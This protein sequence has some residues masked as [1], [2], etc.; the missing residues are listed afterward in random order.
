MKSSQRQEMAVLRAANPVPDSDFAGWSK[1]TAA[2]D[3]L[4][5]VLTQTEPH[6]GLGLQRKRLTTPLV[7][8]A[9]IATIAAALF[10]FLPGATPPMDVTT[11]AS[12]GRSILEAVAATASEQRI[13]SG[14]GEI[15]YSKIKTFTTQTAAGQPMYRFQIWRIQERW[16]APDGSGRVRSQFNEITFPTA[17][18]EEA[19]RAAGSPSLQPRG[20]TVDELRESGDLAYEDFSDL[21]V[22][23][24]LLFAVIEER[25]G[26]AGPG[27]DAEM[28]IVIGD[29]LRFT[30]P[31]P[32]L[33]ASLF[34]VAS[35][36]PG[37][38]VVQQAEDPEG[39]VGIGM[40]L[41]Y[42]DGNGSLV[43][44]NRVFDQQTTHLLG[45]TTTVVGKTD[46]T[47]PAPPPDA[48]DSQQPAIMPPTLTSREGT[49]A[50]ST[51]YLG[52]GTVA[53]LYERP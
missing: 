4:A 41:T 36:I 26:T 16:V 53:S 19:W 52:S 11:D 21:P 3:L 35:R 8:G 17:E 24:D 39:R 25:A 28:F 1:T 37:I 50:T 13:Q 49:V 31:S 7:S 27:K 40:A 18:D 47:S 44:V 10:F 34:R 38:E 32:D 48:P 29:L 14:G 23:T 51:V 30:G 12:G 46:F 15:R 20:G 9:A 22:D 2:R 5:Y 42:D 33:R 43:R 45:E 6:R